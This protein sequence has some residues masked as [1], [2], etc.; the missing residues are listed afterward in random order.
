MNL[1]KEDG[2]KKVFKVK[3]ELKYCI[4]GERGVVWT[5]CNL[6]L[7]K[8]GKVQVLNHGENGQV[9]NNELK[10]NLIV[11]LIK[12]VNARTTRRG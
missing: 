5:C 8:N 12:M 7:G 9:S 6:Y 10:L 2:L 11:S 3:Y 1:P 4:P